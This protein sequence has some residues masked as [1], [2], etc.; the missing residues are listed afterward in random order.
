MSGWGDEEIVQIPKKQTQNQH[1][2]QQQQG[3][4]V[5]Y[6]P[7]QQQQ[8]NSSGGGYQK[9]FFNAKKEKPEEQ[10]AN[11]PVFDPAQDKGQKQVIFRSKQGVFLSNYYLPSSKDKPEFLQK[12]EEPAEHIKISAD[13]KYVLISGFKFVIV[14]DLLNKKVVSKIDQLNSVQNIEISKTQKYIQFVDRMDKDQFQIYLVTFPEMQPIKTFQD[15]VFVK[16]NWPPIK[17]TDDDNLFFKYHYHKQ[18]INLF[19]FAENSKIEVVRQYSVGVVDHFTVAPGNLNNPIF[20]VCS[21]EKQKGFNTVQG[22]IQL[23]EYNNLK[24]IVYQK[25]DKAQEITG[26]WSPEGTYLLVKVESMQDTSNQSYYG[27]N[28]LYYFHVEDKKFEQVPTFKGP[29]HDYKISPDSKY[30]CVISGFIPSQSVLFNNKCQPE[31]EFGKHYKNVCVIS[32]QSRFI[33]LAGFG[34]LNGE[35]EIWD[36]KLKKK[37]GQCKSSTAANCQWSADGQKFMTQ[38]ITP[39]LRVDNNFKIFKYDGTLLHKANFND[40]E[41]YEVQWINLENKSYEDQ[42]P[43]PTALKKFDEKNQE[44]QQQQEKQVYRPP[45]GGS[46][47]A[48]QM[49]AQREAQNSGQGREIK[50]AEELGKN[51]QGNGSFQKPG[52]SQST[53]APKQKKKRIRKKDMDKMESGLQGEENNL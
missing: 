1:Q 18:V 40:T 35:V 16:E 10:K 49:R 42:A 38:V 28:R 53:A 7:K 39:R 50:K 13:Q 52:Q 9:R 48:E 29:V 47:F 45:G 11:E 19:K 36:I 37:V 43:S 21:C 8:S 2:K 20:T 23:Y 27:E 24:P 15:Q 14:Y 41:L 6:Q 5:I 31:F 30:F 4:K 22:K 3:Q 51:L 26:Q 46:S 33:V 17:L 34:N 12:L 44:K 32:P 25:L